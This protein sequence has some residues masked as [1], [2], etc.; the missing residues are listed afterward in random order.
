MNSVIFRAKKW[1][2]LSNYHALNQFPDFGLVRFLYGRYDLYKHLTPFIVDNVDPYSFY[3]LPNEMKPKEVLKEIE[4]N[5]PVYQSILNQQFEIFLACGHGFNQ[6]M[7]RLGWTP[8][9]LKE[10]NYHCSSIRPLSIIDVI[11]MYSDIKASNPKEYEDGEFTR[12]IKEIQEKIDQDSGDAIEDH[13]RESCYSLDKLYLDTFEDHAGLV[14]LHI[15][16]AAKDGELISELQ[17]LLPKLRQLLAKEQITEIDEEERGFHG[18]LVS[19]RDTRKI[20]LTKFRDYKIA[21]LLDLFLWSTVEQIQLSNSD[22]LRLVFPGT[23]NS[24][25][26]VS[27]ANIAN[28]Y[29][30]YIRTCMSFQNISALDK[31]LESQR[32]I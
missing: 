30:P 6:E 14:S 3:K 10:Q 13:V 25:Q 29:L 16:L 1:F 22:Y 26:R 11:Q 28:T 8:T 15:D 27:E 17:K 31:K 20:D 9:W 24:D 32:K 4:Q 18:P 5:D 2:N 19:K 12:V 7:D 23:L 21:A